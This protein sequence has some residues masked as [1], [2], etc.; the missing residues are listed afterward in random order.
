MLSLNR[1]DQPPNADAG[2]AAPTGGTGNDQATVTHTGQYA[3]EKAP[4]QIAGDANQDAN[5]GILAG[6]DRHIAINEEQ[7]KNP[8]WTRLI[9]DVVYSKRK[10]SG[11]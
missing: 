6:A 2:S 3:E 7:V 11:T 1:E 5:D 10:S 9:N 8:H 4:A